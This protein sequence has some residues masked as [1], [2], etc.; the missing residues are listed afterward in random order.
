M[1]L[2]EAASS[3]ISP[4]S[5]RMPPALSSTSRRHIIFLPCAKA[6]PIASAPYCQRAWNVLRIAHSTIAQKP[7]G[8]EPIGIDTV[9]AVL[10]RNAAS[11][12]W[13]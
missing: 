4:A 10:S 9:I 1:T 3:A 2:V 6:A 11:M 13:I 7:F 8:R 5:A 12:V